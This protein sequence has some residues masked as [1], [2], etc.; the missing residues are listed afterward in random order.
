MKHKI[1]HVLIFARYPEPGSVKTRLIPALTPR[2]AARLHRRMT[3]HVL[4][5][6]RTTQRLHGSRADLK[7]TICYTGARRRD[8]RAWLG[9]DLSFVKQ[10]PGDLGLRM[11]GAFKKALHNDSGAVIGIGADVPG[12]TPDIL[13]KA[14]EGLRQKD[15][16]LGRAHDGG[17]YLIGM[18]SL[19]PSVFEGIDWGTDRAYEQTREKIRHLGLAVADMP[20]LSDVDRP[21]DLA[22]VRDDP[23]FSDIFSGRSLISIIIPTL[24]ESGTIGYLLN[25]LGRSD[26]AIE[27][28]VVDGGSRDRTCDIAAREGARVL[29]ASGGRALQQNGG[30]AVARG[31]FLLFLHADTLPPGGYAER[32]YAALDCPTTVAGAFRFKV[33]DP[34]GVMRLV[35]RVTN[36]RSTIFEMP[37]GDQ[38]IFMEKRIFLELGGFQPL[39]IMEDFELVRRLR[40][41]GRIVTLTEAALT[42]GRRW[43]RLGVIRTT[44]INQIMIVGFL[45]GIPIQRLHRFYNRSR[46]PH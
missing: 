25:F 6:V 21:E 37:Y 24:N 26:A 27:R 34:R 11:L 4:E 5:T 36:I 7:I 22:A 30:A 44:L 31:R 16:V 32:I 9:T 13:K 28:I 23:A 33:D 18:K 19:H 8:F 12:I 10:A 14:V 15:M 42:S 43:R 35:E 40:R 3:E 39:R 29:R 17:Y 41:R 20:P 38:G 2:V 45:A 46:E 1:P